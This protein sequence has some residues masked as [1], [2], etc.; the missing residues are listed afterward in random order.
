M[1]DV[2]AIARQIDRLVWA[3]GDTVR[4]QHQALPASSTLEAATFGPLL[5]LIAFRH[6]L[7]EALIRRRYI[8]R[9]EQMMT[10]FVADLVSARLFIRDGDH[11][12]PTE[13]LTPIVAEVDHAIDVA[14]R[15]LWLGH[16]DTVMAA[17]P[18]AREVLHASDGGHGLVAVAQVINE[19]T[20]PFHCFWQRLTGLRLVRNEAHV[21]AWTAF[22]LSASDVEVLS[23][24]WAG[25]A[26][27]GS[28]TPSENLIKHG[29]AADEEVTSEGLAVRQQIED[30]TDDGVSA[31]FAGVD[32]SA[33]LEMLTTLPPWS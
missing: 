19:A 10:T 9:P 31:A 7:T 4:A 33:F 1:S 27:Q 2:E 17:S 6:H 3:V 8:Y 15:E 28:T 14:C 32:S 20:D 16:E 18:M 21:D 22:D 24:A 5:N 30:A 26:L 12:T 13:L 29:Y 23:G 11:L 25:T